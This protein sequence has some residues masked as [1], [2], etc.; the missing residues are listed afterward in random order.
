MEF[1]DPKFII[2]TVGLFG[3]FAVVFAETG[4]FFGFFLP[5][6]SL[7]FTA[8]L[9]S[10]QGYFSIYALSVGCFI[11]S[12]LGDSFGYYFG[13]KV[14]VKLFVKEDSFFF[15]KK[16]ISNAQHF[17]EKYGKKAIILARF[18]PIA[19][20]FVPIVAGIG[21]MSYKSFVTSNVLGGAVWSFGM[22]FGGYWLGTLIPSVDKYLLPIIF[23]I[24]FVSFIPVFIEYIK[25][26]R[27]D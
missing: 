1:L 11:A 20:T 2:Q 26:K 17:Y 19:R 12:V 7:L 18:V 24:I 25:A 4:L 22:T 13:K 8:G 5:G 9:L 3:V 14:G 10:S 6:D 27:Q 15:H 23:I 21:S 16:H